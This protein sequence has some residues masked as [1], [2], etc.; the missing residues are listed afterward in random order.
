MHSRAVQRRAS[1]AISTLAILLLGNISKTSFQGE[2][3]ESSRSY[4]EEFEYDQYGNVI[5]VKHTEDSNDSITEY[6]YSYEHDQI[7]TCKTIADGKIVADTEYTYDDSG[8]VIKSYVSQS[9]GAVITIKEDEYDEHNNLT[10]TTLTTLVG[11]VEQMTVT[12]YENEY[13]QK[14]K[15]IRTTQSIV[16]ENTKQFVTE[17]E[18][19]YE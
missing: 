13:D 6:E 8:N 7:K 18:Y 1:T 19:I 11:S 15:L 9:N 17:Y 4:T 10:Q 14:S 3:S 2:Y 12:E 5:F 16:N